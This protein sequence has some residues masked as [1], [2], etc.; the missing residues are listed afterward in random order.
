MDSP[1][2]WGGAVVALIGLLFAG[3]YRLSSGIEP[4]DRQT[5][6]DQHVR[7]DSD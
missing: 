2:V 6:H 4:D 5:E 3:L 7:G 1:W